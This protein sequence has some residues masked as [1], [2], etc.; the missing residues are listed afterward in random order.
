MKTIYLIFF[1]ILF[2]N[3]A[4]TKSNQEENISQQLIGT[5]K[6]TESYISEGGP[7]FWVPVENEFTYT[8]SN[9][10]ELITSG[11]INCEGTYTFHSNDLLD[12]N[13]NCTEFNLHIIPGITYKIA[14][15][16]DDVLSF[17]PDPML[18]DEGC[19]YKL[20]KISNN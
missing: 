5:W 13:P 20:I 4:C 6:H 8:F 9:S 14:F 17:V 2:M 7:G 16:G 3:T 12:F 11:E 19:G 18:C 1:A 10:N 15:G